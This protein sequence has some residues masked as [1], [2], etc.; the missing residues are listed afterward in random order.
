MCENVK[1]RVVPIFGPEKCT[2]LQVHS[3]PGAGCHRLLLKPTTI[4]N[5]LANDLWL[6]AGAGELPAVIPLTSVMDLENLCGHKSF[7]K[8]S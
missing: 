5:F 7:L 4:E 6:L 3:H 1:N 8:Q 2:T